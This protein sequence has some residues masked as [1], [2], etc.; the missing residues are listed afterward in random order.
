MKNYP[1]NISIFFL[2][3]S[4]IINAQ[5]GIGNSNPD[6]S[7][8]LEMTSTTQ[9]LLIPRMT[10]S[11]RDLIANP[12]QGLL[13][14]NTTISNFNYYDAPWKEYSKDNNSNSYS[15]SY[16][17]PDNAVT[18]VLTGD[19]NIPEMTFTPSSAGTYEVSFNCSFKNSLLPNYVYP[20]TIPSALG[21]EANSDLTA[22]ITS[23]NAVTVT[24]N[25]HDPV[26]GS[27][28]GETLTAGV[29]Y[30]DGAA[31]VAGKL[32]FDGGENDFFIIKINGAL[33]VGAITQMFLTGGVKAENIMWLVNGAVAVA[34]TSII[35]GNVIVNGTGAIAFAA[36]GNLEG[37]LLTTS[38]AINFGP[39]V[40]TVPTG[41]SLF[42]FGRLASFVLF[43]ASG[44]VL[45]TSTSTI[46]GDVGTLLGAFTGF[47][48]ANFKGAYVTSTTYTSAIPLLTYLPNSNT[49]LTYFS[50]YKD[51]ILIP[52][53]TKIVTSLGEFQ[54]A[55]LQVI[56]TLEVN[57][58]IDIRW[59]TTTE[60]IVMEN[61]SLLFRRLQ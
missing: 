37:R 49:N 48:V 24:N 47:E 19:T 59:R 43:T 11:E 13:I 46:T 9:G 41:T 60:K 55:S 28:V 27:A 34:A 15:Y 23:L 29:Y 39:A 38:G 30:I 40:A 56:L 33:T 54:N 21:S 53:F 8:I 12:A 52:S 14:Y 16:S 36:G 45:N 22:L 3:L 44:G 25:T 10:S 17:N 1:Q 5:V 26:F 51:G 31:S 50:I 2:T 57:K 61:S 42:T 35:K 32:T 7:S 4:G 20:G 18:T 58:S 6:A